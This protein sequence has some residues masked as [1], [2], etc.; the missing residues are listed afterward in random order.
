VARTGA[1]HSKWPPWQNSAQAFGEAVLASPRDY[2]PTVITVLLLA[3]GLLAVV[4]APR[5]IPIVAP[6]LVAITLFVLV[7]GFPI[8]SWVRIWLTNPW[9]SDSNRLAAL[10]PIAA[11]PVA[12]LGVVAVTDAA[13]ALPLP[14][15]LRRRTIRV[16]VAGVGIAILFTVGF[17]ANVR[18]ALYQVREAYAAVPDALLLSPDERALLSRL[19]EEVPADALLIGSPRT[20]AS[21][22]YAL[23]DRDVTELHIFGS[24]SADEKFLDGHLRD[25]DTDPAV[26]RAVGRVG[27]THVLDFAGRDVFD[28]AVAAKTYDGVQGLDAT[29]HLV[30]IDSQGDAKLFRIDGC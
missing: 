29:T 17:G 14:Q 1:E 9:Y 5:R 24:P 13:R 25:I 20:G 3:V 28:D 11:I 4:R 23:A 16:V 21:L 19:D 15:A 8:D 22:A 26:C 10:L 6:F 12:T 30:L 7:S 18:D 27:V 2:T